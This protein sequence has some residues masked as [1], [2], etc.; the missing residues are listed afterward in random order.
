MTLR[1]GTLALALAAALLSPATRADTLDFDAVAGGALDTT[2]LSLPQ[3][4][5]TAAGTTLYNLKQ[6]YFVGAGGAI[7]S[8][9]SSGLCDSD[10]SIDFTAPVSGLTFRTDGYHP[11]DSVTVYAYAGATLLGTDTVTSN[12]LV[13]LSAYSGITRLF[14]DDS[15][16]AAGY[17]Y[18]AFSF[19]TAV[20]EPQTY[21][22]MLAGLAALGAAAHR[23]RG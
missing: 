16:T 6:F 15:S 13:D 18:G 14:L 3:A 2:V 1:T 22:L 9:S 5:I 11:G 17:G 8:I 7:C 4:T 21:A 12:R 10:L 20:P 23:R 19:T